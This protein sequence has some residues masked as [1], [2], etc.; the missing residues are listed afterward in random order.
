MSMRTIITATL[1]LLLFGCASKDSVAPVPDPPDD[2]RP[3]IETLSEAQRNS[4]L[5]IA[6]HE[7]GNLDDWDKGGSPNAGGGV[8]NTGGSDVQAISVP[9]VA[10]SGE[11]AAKTTITNA[12]R[13]ENGNKAVRLMRWTDKSWEEGGDYFPD[14]AYYSAWVF[15]PE[16]CNPNKYDPWDPGDGGWWN[17]FQFKSNDAAG[18]SQ[19]MWTLNVAHNDNTGVMSFYFWSS[20]LQQSFAQNGVVPMPVAEWFHLEARVVASTGPSG[21]ITL[22]QNGIEI[23]DLQAIQTVL[24][25]ESE[26]P[27]WGIGNYTNHIACGGQEGS[28]TIYF[29]DAAVSTLSLSVGN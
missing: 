4:I 17:V 3:W 20:L 27:I 2:P 16:T 5:W 10:H 1:L 13:A 18:V 21:R 19:P 29:D 26:K 12:I 6:D 23:F 8:F 14:T 24:N 22:W 7:E 11:F 9:G 15:M 25:G 28:A